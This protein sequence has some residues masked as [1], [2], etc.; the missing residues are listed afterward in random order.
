MHV[1]SCELI[2]FENIKDVIKIEIVVNN[3]NTIIYKEEDHQ[4]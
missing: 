3:K 1:L 2:C 4:H